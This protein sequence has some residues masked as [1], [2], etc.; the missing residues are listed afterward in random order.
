MDKD[1]NSSKPLP[2]I[3]SRNP[4]ISFDRLRMYFGDP[5]TIDFEDL[6]GAITIYSPTIGDIM[7]IGEK[8]FY[9]TLMLLITNTTAN[10]LMLWEAGI[11]WNEISDF[12]LFSMFI[13]TVDSDIC[14]LLFGDLDLTKFERMGKQVDDEQVLVLYNPEAD[15]EI[16]ELAY[17]H[18]SQYLRTVFNI[19][20]EEKLTKSGY[21]KEWYIRQ[22][23]M[24]KERDN[25]K[26]KQSDYSSVL[27]AQI[28][29]FIC[30]P[31]TKYKLHELKEVG[32]CEFF[33]TLQR[34]Q[35]YESATALMKGMY[36][37]FVDTKHIKPEEYNFMREL[38]SS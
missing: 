35:I 38:K 32:V 19:F 10:K 24:Q 6:R 33:D 34:L 20:P 8:K 18:I 3:K 12:E 21:L 13:K 4:V 7:E 17:F 1:S 31:G 29:S 5:Y 23:K 2:K 9:Q 16:N 36:S 26:D 22:E 25:K 28:S 14:K 30:H 11:D 15:V 37:G 27:Q